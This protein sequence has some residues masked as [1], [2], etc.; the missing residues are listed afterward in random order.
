[1]GL[2]DS[3]DLGIDAQATQ[4]SCWGNLVFA[5]FCTTSSSTSTHPRQWAHPSLRLRPRS[6][7]VPHCGQ[8]TSFPCPWSSKACRH[9]LQIT[10]LA[11]ERASARACRLREIAVNIST[12]RLEPSTTS[13]TKSASDRSI[14]GL[15][16]KPESHGDPALWRGGLGRK[17]N[18]A[19]PV[20]ECCHS[21]HL[22]T[23]K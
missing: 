3:S 2:S 23:G 15:V 12:S 10:R 18:E 1:M 20:A 22:A 14:G 6:L 9:N 19:Q 13:T 8:S 7:A 4:N 16:G 11:A 17:G 5:Y 21:G